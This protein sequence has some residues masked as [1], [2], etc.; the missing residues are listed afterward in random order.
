MDAMVQ[1]PAWADV[2]SAQTQPLRPT[3]EE[4]LQQ[5]GAIYGVAREDLLNRMHQPAFQAAIA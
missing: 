1:D 2:L 5:V 4:V 3:P